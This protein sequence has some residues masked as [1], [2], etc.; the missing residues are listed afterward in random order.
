VT[1]WKLFGKFLGFALELAF[2]CALIYGGV[3]LAWWVAG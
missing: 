2:I 3:M 1:N